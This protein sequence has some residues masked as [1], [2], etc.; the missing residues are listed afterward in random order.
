MV[1]D[2][3]NRSLPTCDCKTGYFGLDPNLE[4]F[5]CDD[6]C[7]KCSGT[8]DNCDVCRPGPN[9]KL[10]PDC[11]CE[12]GYYNNEVNICV[13]CRHPCSTCDD[14]DT[15]KVCVMDMDPNRHDIM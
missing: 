10:K 2:G 11:T 6:K 3:E 14:A 5:K 15:C 12:D 7:K 9:R 13:P 4:C 8:S 1:C